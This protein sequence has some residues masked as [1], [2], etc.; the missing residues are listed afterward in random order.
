MKPVPEPIVSPEDNT[1][2]IN[3][4]KIFPW[5]F[6]W[7][8]N[9]FPSQF[10]LRGDFFYGKIYLMKQDGEFEFYGVN[11]EKDI[12]YNMAVYMGDFANTFGI[13]YVYVTF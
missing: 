13:D 4:G 11:Y 8:K 1:S 2:D 12:I 6:M 5:M 10:R 7:F 9:D 3:N